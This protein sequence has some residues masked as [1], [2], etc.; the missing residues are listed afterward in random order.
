[1]VRELSLEEKEEIKSILE[2][3]IIE[4]RR[5]EIY[6]NYL[7]SKKEYNNGNLNFYDNIDDLKKSI[8]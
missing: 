4:S 6:Q 8:G 3:D 1:M 7:D 5:A 2:K